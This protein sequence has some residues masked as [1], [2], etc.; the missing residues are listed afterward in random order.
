MV[1]ETRP[2]FD[3]EKSDVVANAAVEDV[4][5]NNNELVSP[6]RALIANLPKGDVVPTPTFPF[7][8]I[9]KAPFALVLGLN[10]KSERPEVDW[11][12]KFFVASPGTSVSP[13]SIESRA[14]IAA[15][16]ASKVA[17][18]ALAL[19]PVAIWKIEPGLVVPIPTLWFVLS[20]NR[21]LLSN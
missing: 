11:K 17:S 14:E 7:A 1:A 10:E 2:I 12:L 16:V 6:E 19:P 4:M 15:L 5:L 3:I 13:A 8:L 18:V 21:V 20:T 9:T